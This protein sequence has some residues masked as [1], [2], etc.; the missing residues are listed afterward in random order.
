[1][2]TLAL[3]DPPAAN[4]PN[5]NSKAV[6]WMAKVKSELEAFG[7]INGTPIAQQFQVGSFTTN[8]ALSGTSTGTDIA[9]F[10][11]SLVAAMISK[12][13]VSQTVSRSNG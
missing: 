8:T 12:G 7:R 11:S 6:G 10:V 9:N 5:F 13:I 2:R 1:M 4:D 3:P